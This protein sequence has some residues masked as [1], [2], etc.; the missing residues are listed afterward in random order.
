MLHYF[1]YLDE[2]NGFTFSMETQL[3]QDLFHPFQC[4]SAFSALISRTVT[5]YLDKKKKINYGNNL[6]D[7]QGQELI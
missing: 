6:V 3:S 4:T 5:L 2:D 1:N 7:S